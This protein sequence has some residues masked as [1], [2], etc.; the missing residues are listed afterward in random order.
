[1]Q[2]RFCPHRDEVWPDNRHFSCH[3]NFFHFRFRNIF[4][5]HLL[6]LFHE[7]CEQFTNVRGATS[8]EMVLCLKKATIPK[9]RHRSEIR[10]LR[11][12]ESKLEQR[13]I[14]HVCRT[15]YKAN[16]Y[17]HFA[18]NRP[19]ALYLSYILPTSTFNTQ[20]TYLATV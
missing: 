7:E 15:V 11:N 10:L 4:T 12:L 5:T 13:I 17:L 6:F 9:S 18:N 2:V 20:F 3:K 14:L 19:S 16:N 1:M 8:Q